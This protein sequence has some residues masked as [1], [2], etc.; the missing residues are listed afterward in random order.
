MWILVKTLGS[1]A[2]RSELSLTS[3]PVMSCPLFFRITTTSYAVQPPVPSR[4]ISIGRGARLRP[5]PSGAPSM[6]TT[7][8]LPVSARNVMPSP[9][10][11]TLHSIGGPFCV[12]SATFLSS[13]HENLHRQDGRGRPG[14]VRARCAGQ[15]ARQARDPDRH[16]AAP[17]A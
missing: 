17:Q 4:T 6:A 13:G 11:R 12:K 9:V 3:Q 1:V 15:G 5:P 16:P 2:A 7:W 14:L 8:L 10:H